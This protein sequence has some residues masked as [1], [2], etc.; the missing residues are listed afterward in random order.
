MYDMGLVLCLKC[1]SW[2][3]E[4]VVCDDKFFCEFYWIGMEPH[5][6]Y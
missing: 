5:F 2:V 1:L 6:T 3:A 4:E